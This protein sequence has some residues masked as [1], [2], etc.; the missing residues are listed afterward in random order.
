MLYMYISRFGTNNK[1]QIPFYSQCI[2]NETM[3]HT[4][5]IHNDPHLTFSFILSFPFFVSHIHT[6]AEEGWDLGAVGC[7]GAEMLGSFCGWLA[8]GGLVLLDE[9]FVLPR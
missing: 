1:V 9:I 7:S 8:E 2:F 6:Q 3:I 5:M 4:S